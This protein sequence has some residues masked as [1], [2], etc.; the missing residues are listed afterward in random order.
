MIE[1][2]LQIMDQ[3]GLTQSGFANE[4]GI[5]RANLSN[6]INGKYNVSLE[7]FKKIT[8]RFTYID[9]DWLLSGNGN[10]KRETKQ[11]T[12]YVIQPD[13]F[14]N[15]PN[16]QPEKKIIPEYRKEIKDKK[17]S[18][19]SK[20]EE[21]EPVIFADTPVKKVVKIIIYY[22]DSTHEFFNPEK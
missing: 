10:W 17:P 12:N 2:I 16:I 19:P 21:N 11:T 7:I 13:L 18:I 3:E 22:S 9:P 14:S 6:I 5:K 1:R 15:P 20:I 4:I 8:D